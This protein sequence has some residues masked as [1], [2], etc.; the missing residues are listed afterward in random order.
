MH[1]RV[2]DVVRRSW[3]KRQSR[4]AKPA[5]PGFSKAVR[6]IVGKRSI[7]MC[8]ID[9]CGPSA[10]LHHR[11]PRGRGGSR[12]TWINQPANALALALACHNRIESHRAMAEANGWLV[13]RNRTLTA[14]EVPALYRGHWVYLTDDGRIHPLE[15]S[16]ARCDGCYAVLV[17]D[18]AAAAGWSVPDD[19]THWCPGCANNDEEGEP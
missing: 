7:G 11:A 16:V 4:R 3:P 10:H 9:F 5:S 14:T 6:L 18:D 2:Q 13:P 12:L 15:G 19:G 17:H 8:E 1:P